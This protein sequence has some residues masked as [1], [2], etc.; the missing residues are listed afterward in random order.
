[1]TDRLYSLV[2]MM[3]S[4]ASWICN[5][6]FSFFVSLRYLVLV[7]RECLSENYLHQPAVASVFVKF[8]NLSFLVEFKSDVIKDIS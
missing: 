1:M 7:S 2:K 4:F 6:F 3:T 8:V 5:S